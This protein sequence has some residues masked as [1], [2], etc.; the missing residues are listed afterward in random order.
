MG[1]GFGVGRVA[2]ENDR[3][4]TFQDG[5]QRNANG[6]TDMVVLI[7]PNV[8]GDRYD[9]IKRLLC[10]DM[11]SEFV[12]R[13]RDFYLCF[14]AV[15]SQVILSKTLSNERSFSGVVQK[16]AGQMICKLGGALWTIN[17][18][19]QKTMIVGYDTY[20]DSAQKGKSVGAVVASM[21]KE[22][23]KYFSV[24]THHI[25]SE[26]LTANFESSLTREC[27]CSDAELKASCFRVPGRLQ[28]GERRLSGEG[29]DLPRR[30]G[31]G[32]AE[33]SEGREFCAVVHLQ[34]RG[35][36][37]ALQVEVDSI[38]RALLRVCPEARM[39]FIVVTKRTNV[40][41]F[42]KQGNAYVN[43]HPGVVVDDTITCPE[44]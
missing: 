41:I 27:G 1:E 30:R 36:N 31:R 35:D 28:A 40:R 39:A 8:R 44:Q 9:A 6:T 15:P 11:P 42:M 29:A 13:E 16:V 26:E 32:P 37:F 3:T 43:P 34:G 4:G 12:C 23:T 10:V 2:L 14:S 19:L 24:A 21:D 18:P 33:P 5:V 7:F 38:K 17:I 25:T 22:C 20:H